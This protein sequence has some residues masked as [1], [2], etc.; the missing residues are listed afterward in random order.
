VPGA[1]SVTAARI[2]V[3]R[4][5]KWDTSVSVEGFRWEAGVDA[6]ASYNNVGPSYFRTLGIPILA[7][8]EF[9]T[10]DGRTAPRVAIVNQA[11]ARK[12]GLEERNVIGSRMALG[13]GQGELDIEIVGLVRDANYSQVKEQA[14]PM[15]FTPWRQ[16]E[17]GGLTFYVRMATDP[18]PVLA[19]IPTMVR[20]LDAN[21]PVQNLTTL[22]HQVKE[23]VFLDRMISALTAAFAGLATLLAAIGLFGVMAYTVAQRTREIGLRMALGA[24]SAAI[25]RMVLGQVGRMVL[26]GGAIGIVAA[27]ALGRAAGSLL[28]GVEGHDPVVV[29]VGVLLLA[30]VA[31]GAGYLPARRAARVDPM[32]ALREE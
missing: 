31:M 10:A 15:F 28:Y 9:T 19:T 18:R 16:H 1:T 14:P 2:A 20:R 26:V 17:A 11:F 6:A 21:L 22:R 32:I 27:L 4:N 13:L 25:R 23:N 30:L 8:R 7:G 29:A 5:D 24:Q 12:F 3:L